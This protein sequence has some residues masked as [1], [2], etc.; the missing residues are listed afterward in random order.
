MPL[1]DGY[2]TIILF[3]SL[4]AEYGELSGIV[5]SID[6]SGACE[7]LLLDKKK[8]KKKHA[9]MVFL[10]VTAQTKL[11][12]EL[13]LNMLPQLAASQSRARP[14]LRSDSDITQPCSV[15]LRLKGPYKVETIL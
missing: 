13:D 6:S 2:R 15:A 8:K 10:R 9:F 11:R 3:S 7:G 14:G 1:P 12:H 5:V 4:Y